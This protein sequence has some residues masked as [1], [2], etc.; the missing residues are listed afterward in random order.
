MNIN[1]TAAVVLCLLFIA[2]GCTSTFVITK[3]GKSYFFGNRSEG[4]YK[5]LCESGDLKKIVADARLPEE[6][7]DLLYKYNC[8]DVDNSK[9]KI[10]AIYESLK[11]EQRRDLRLA[12]QKNGYDINVMDC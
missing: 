8:T 3:D 9:D 6:Q 10:T 1:K 12:F 11:S 7:A 2:A 5:M 4:F